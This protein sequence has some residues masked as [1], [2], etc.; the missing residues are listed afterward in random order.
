M[1]D[2]APIQALCRLQPHFIDTL[3]DEEL[4]AF[5]WDSDVWLRPQQRVPEGDWR[6]C[7]WICGR[8]FGKTMGIA[9]EVNRRVRQGVCNAVA[10]AAPTIERVRDVQIKTLL[11]LSP[12]WFPAE[13]YG[14]TIRWPNGVVAEV[15]SPVKPG[16]PRGGNFDLVWM[17]ELVDW[18]VD[19]GK[20]SGGWECFSNLTTGCR[21]GP[22][23]QCMIDTTSKGRNLIIRFLRKQSAQFPGEHLM[24]RGHMLD[25]FMLSPAYI[26]GEF[27][28]YPPGT[29]AHQEEIEGLDFDEA[30]S[31]LWRQTWIDAHRVSEAPPLKLVVVGVDPA[32]STYRESDETGIVLAGRDHRGHVYLMSDRTARHKPDDWAEIVVK[33]HFE[34]RCTGA[35]IE[36]NHAGDYPTNTL[37]TV[38]KAQDVHVELLPESRAN[39]RPM[40][41][42][43]KG[44]IYVREVVSSDSKSVRAAPAASMARLGT[45]HHVGEFPTLED[46]MANWIPGGRSPNRLDAAAQAV[47]E[48]AGAA[49]VKRESSGASVE[50]ACAAQAA[51]ASRTSEVLRSRPIGTRPRRGRLGI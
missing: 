12:P 14:D 22:R 19:R 20:D 38:A 1:R 51:L 9:L 45:L 49:R 48:L 28:K 3:T 24:V 31:A 2:I 5:I 4:L 17:T 18:P 16:R 42:W 30:D 44:V 27:R 13:S 47:V 21:V 43:R 32:L 50:H 23:P 37:R 35:V 10:L 15:Y 39:Q 41:S 29:R 8:G 11:A 33:M 34:D 6:T 46:Q 7:T 36:R 40:P 25:N 26:R